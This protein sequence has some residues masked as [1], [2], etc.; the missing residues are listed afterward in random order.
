MTTYKKIEEI[1]GIK[2]IVPDGFKLVPL[3]EDELKVIPMSL[4]YEHLQLCK[5]VRDDTLDK[6]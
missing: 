2:Y 6:Q 4:Q 5:L 1:T 3:T